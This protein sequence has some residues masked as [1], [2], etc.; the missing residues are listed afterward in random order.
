MQAEEGKSI[1]LQCAR[2]TNT[3]GWEAI[4][5]LSDSSFLTG[6]E[7]IECMQLVDAHPSNFPG[8][9]FLKADLQ[10]QITPYKRNELIRQTMQAA[11]KAAKP[12]LLPLG[13]WL[14]RYNAFALTVE[15]IPLPE[16]LKS[17]DLL[18]IY[19]DAVAAQNDW[20]AVEAVLNKPD[21]PL[22]PVII[23]IFQ[24]RT[25]RELRQQRVPE[26]FW[27]QAYT[28]AGKDEESLL[29]LARY[30]A[31]AGELAHAEK[32]YRAFLALG[33]NQRPA[34]EE[35]VQ[36]LELEGD[37][38]ALKELLR[39]M[40]EKYPE[41]PLSRNDL[42]Y[43]NLLLKEEVEASKAVAL[44]LT[45]QYPRMLSYKVTLALGYLR[46][47]EPASALPLFSGLNVNWGQA[48][49][50]WQ[51]IYAAVLGSNGQIEQAAKIARQA[52]LNRLK[53]EERSLLQPYLL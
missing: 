33:K 51:A 24:A 30:A 45:Q 35:L 14:N 31:K 5:V 16:A 52:P 12:E 49:P 47:Q 26:I 23:K 28:M 9:E 43:L 39:E 53:T 22:Q 17:K 40:T 32:A 4:Q 29:F 8:K 15:A 20:A 48:L 10:I 42:A 18:L 44:S 37:T 38:R 7:A 13:R 1:L 11:L 3:F 46:S 2:W 34:Y 25:A 19:L 41:D 6:P 36:V 50:G 27:D 21:L